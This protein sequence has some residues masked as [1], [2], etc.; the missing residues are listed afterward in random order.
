[1][2]YRV[3]KMKR[4]GHRFYDAEFLTVRTPHEAAQIYA[5]ERGITGPLK[6]ISWS[7]VPGYVYW[8]RKMLEHI[9]VFPEPEIQEGKS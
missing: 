3:A 1:M 2:T 6:R 9:A 7:V 5:K 8:T 4:R